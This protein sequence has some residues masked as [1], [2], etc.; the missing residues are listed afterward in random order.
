MFAHDRASLTER[1]NT[2]DLLGHSKQ[3]MTELYHA[4]RGLDARE[5]R[6]KV[7]ELPR[8]RAQEL[9]TTP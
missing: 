4:E 3:A 6:W 7:V 2:Q 8:P 9:A 5:D 1:I